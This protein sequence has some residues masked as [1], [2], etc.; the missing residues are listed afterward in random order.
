MAEGVDVEPFAKRQEREAR[1]ICDQ[2]EGFRLN[3]QGEAFVWNGIW[4][5]R[6]ATR[7]C[8]EYNATRWAKYDS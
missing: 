7:Q 8:P 3:I 4:M 6:V 2:I 1:W 5:F